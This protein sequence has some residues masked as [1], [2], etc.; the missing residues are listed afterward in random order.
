MELRELRETDRVSAFHCGDPDL[1]RFLAKYARRNEFRS[2][3][4]VTY[5][6]ADLGQVAGF[7]SVLPGL[8]DRPDGQALPVLRVGRLAVDQSWRGRGLRAVMLRFVLHL[9]CR[10][11]P[12]LGCAGIVIDAP[13]ELA[14]WYAR[15]GFLEL[16]VL[17]G[18]SPAR[19]RPVA[20]WLGMNEI[21]AALPGEE[22]AT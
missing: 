1:D 2:H 3:L 20:M 15:L 21:A 5:V 10:T 7:C 17:E 11:D 13:P 22:P 14:G 18:G 8:L 19:P 12:G 4:G 9:A 6:A 16:E